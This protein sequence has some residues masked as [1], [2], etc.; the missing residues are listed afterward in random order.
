MTTTAR[1]PRAPRSAT[2]CGTVAW[3]GGDDRQIR[4]ERQLVDRGIG[5]HALDRHLMRVDRHDRPVETCV[6][7]V[8]GE[9][10]ADRAR[11]LA[12]ADQARSSA[13]GTERRDCGWTSFAYALSDR[14]QGAERRCDRRGE[15]SE[16]KAAVSRIVIGEQILPRRAEPEL[17]RRRQPD[18]EKTNSKRC[19][20]RVAPRRPAHEQP[21]SQNDKDSERQR[22]DQ[23]G[24]A[25]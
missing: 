16:A 17:E 18:P 10:R 24:L 8:M 15:L 13:G 6:E 25:W 11:L 4:D 7:E 2:I 1:V 19:L 12:R 21:C 20:E 22:R 3:R 14:C 5:E 23:L 9:H